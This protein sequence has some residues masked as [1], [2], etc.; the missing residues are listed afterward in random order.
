MRVK[1]KLFITI[2]AFITIPLVLVSVFFITLKFL[3]I[4]Y[5][6][7][8]KNEIDSQ[9]I[10]TRNNKGV[11]HIDAATIDDFYFA[12][13][14]LHAKDRLDAM[15][16]LRAIATGDAEK[17][18]G[19]DSALLNKLSR[20]IGFTKNAD[21]IYAKFK[22][23]E[24]RC[25]ANYIKGINHVRGKAHVRNLISREWSIQD[26]LSIISLKEWANSYLNNVEL[27]FNLP[28]SKLQ[29]IKNI[30]LDNKYIHF[31]N[32]DDNQYLYI[33]RRIKEVTEKYICTF[34][35]GNAIYAGP[36]YSL[37]ESDSYTTLNYEDSFNI[38]PGWYPV[39]ATI[40]GKKILAITYN[41]MP[42]LL[43]FKNET[44]SLVHV[45]INADS[46]N[47]YFFETENKNNISQYKSAGRWLEYKTVRIPALNNNDSSSEIKWHTEKGPILSELIS[48]V[49]TDSRILVIES[50]QPGYDYINLMMKM[51]FETDLEK[52][53]Q[54]ALTND[55]SLKCF[56]L[57]DNK[58]AYKIYAGYINQT[59]N[60][61]RV[62]IDGSKSLKPPFKRINLA[63]KINAPDYSGSDLVADREIPSQNVITNSFKIERFNSLLQKKQQY[64][65]D[66]LR[67]FITDDVSV[68][69][70]KFV[71][72]FR[73]MLENNVLTS[74]KLSRIFFSD[75]DF[76][77]N[78]GLQAPS[79]FFTTLGYFIQETY[80]DKFG[81]D[82]DFNLASAYLLY[83]ELYDQC[84][85]KLTNIFDNTETIKVE[86]REM[87][88]DIAFLNAMRF[89]NRKSGPYMDSWRWGAINKSAFDMHN[90]KSNFFSHF[91][92][93]DDQPFTGGPDTI[94][95]L[96]QN[97]KFQSV[98]ATSINTFMTNDTIKFRM[99]FGYS[100]SLLSDFYYGDTKIED[101]QD[102]DIITPVYKTVFSKK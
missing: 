34:L 51:P 64:N 38:Y 92:D 86:N 71:P 61:S 78:S 14:Y 56:L 24:I 82:S 30:F 21:D 6:T 63:S 18:A 31:Y 39:K 2:I 74:A 16:Y 42:L 90:I 76:S 11:P 88:F 46:Q 32:E 20:T 66:F 1:K 69:A 9:I 97:N 102:L 12:L 23:D 93:V 53:K 70:E 27:L 91:Y 54:L 73:L 89:L 87:I 22:K 80:K 3:K 100:I 94:Q 43:S 36:E 75:W 17:F 8:E 79:I 48:S 44:A 81:R 47:F 95:N 50:V 67:D 60:N 68:T 58:K 35:R 62:F 85:K 29:S 57:S 33:L 41:G 96:M 59:G 13:G 7:Y 99:N 5:N 101:F 15:E 10:I 45:N 19:N 28:E 52:I 84:Q 26:V 55:S 25:F 98:S 65:E 49:K 4:S 72:L 77:T 37:N 83:P 40:N